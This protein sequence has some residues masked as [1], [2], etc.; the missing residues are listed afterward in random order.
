MSIHAT[1]IVFGEAGVLIRG[2]PGAGKSTLALRLIDTEGYGA[3]DVPLRAKLV[4]DDQVELTRKDDGLFA[5]PPPLL[6][7]LLELRG[8]GLMPFP[9][10]PSARIVLVVDLVAD[11]KVDRL[12]EKPFATVQLEGI[13]LPGIILARSDPSGPAKLRSAVSLTVPD[14]AASGG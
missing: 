11:A 7:G 12:P 5:S 2:A 3:G 4:A 14:R 13:N 10:Q 8:I 9:Y 6:A 1:A